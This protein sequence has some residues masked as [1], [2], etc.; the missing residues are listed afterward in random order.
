MPISTDNENSQSLYA[1]GARIYKLYYIENCLFLK[2][3]KN[4]IQ[5][6]N[7]PDPKLGSLLTQ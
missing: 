5:S 6:E 2:T 4:L 3:Y 1:L 7:T